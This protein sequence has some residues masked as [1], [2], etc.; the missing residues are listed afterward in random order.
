MGAGAVPAGQALTPERLDTLT[1]AHAEAIARYDA[2]A[3]LRDVSVLAGAALARAL[4]E[5]FANP[6]K[7]SEMSAVAE[8]A[9]QALDR[10]LAHLRS[11]DGGDISK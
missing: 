1:R 5:A 3:H 10:A 2:V 4:A 6:E 7:A 8:V 9:D 11:V